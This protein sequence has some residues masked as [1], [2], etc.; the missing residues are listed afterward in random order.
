MGRCAIYTKLQQRGV[1]QLSFMRNGP[2]ADLLLPRDLV[3]W[4]QLYSEGGF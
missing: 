4:L 3:K 1:R 2:L